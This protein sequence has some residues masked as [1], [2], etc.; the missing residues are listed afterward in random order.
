MKNILLIAILVLLLVSCRTN[1]PAAIPPVN[2]IEVIRDRIVTIPSV[3]DSSMLKALFECDSNNR[4]VLKAY[5]A[6]YSTYMSAVAAI[7]PVTDG[8]MSIT[9]KTNTNHPATT[10]AVH[11]SVVSKEKLIY[12]PGA[13][14]PV[15]KEL[16]WI[17]KTLIYTGAAAL[18]LLLIFIIVKIYNPLKLIKP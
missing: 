9:I 8:G 7:E 14:Y 11:D 18:A 10:A 2:T 5:N 12:M 15:E 17:Q 13:P 3:Q 6:L 4:V 16:N 1:K